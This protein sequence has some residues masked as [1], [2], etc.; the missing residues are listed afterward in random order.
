M[1][2]NKERI[3]ENR[4]IMYQV[5]LKNNKNFIKDNRR[6]ANQHYADNKEKKLKYAEDYRNDSLNKSKIEEYLKCYAKAN[7][8]HLEK[9]NKTWRTEHKKELS[10]YQRNKKIKDPYY[11]IRSAI[12]SQI[13]TALKKQGG[14][15]E[16]VSF[17]RAIGYTKYDLKHHLDRLL[18]SDMNWGNYGKYWVVDHII[19]RSFFKYQ[20]MQ[21][22]EFKDCWTLENLRP[23]LR[24]ENNI[25][26]NR[27]TISNKMVEDIYG[28][29]RSSKEVQQLQRGLCG[30]TEIL[31]NASS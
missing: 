30:D 9:Y 22:Q 3:K 29:I 16:G 13:C 8:M 1:I 26:G 28:K 11:R 20:N 19:P 24:I 14:S 31:C 27:V 6:K 15:K 18:T 5:R 10:E 2:D 4:A 12:S 25:R 23:L 7:K 21:D 17:F